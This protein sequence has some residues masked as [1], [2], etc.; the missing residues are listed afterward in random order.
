MQYF[1]ID[2]RK[3]AFDGLCSNVH[4]IREGRE[5][6]TYI[7]WC[8]FTIKAQ[9]ASVFDFYVGV[10]KAKRDTLRTPFH[11]FGGGEGNRT[12]VRKPI[13][14]TFYEYIRLFAFPSYAENRHSA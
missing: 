10:A 4:T 11:F 3:R 6:L 7:C 8:I 12:P 9:S 5:V 13:L 1:S 14:T 2:L